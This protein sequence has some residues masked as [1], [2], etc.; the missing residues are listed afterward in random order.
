MLT[1]DIKNDEDPELVQQVIDGV[2]PVVLGYPEC[3]SEMLKPGFHIVVSV[4]RIVSVTSN[5]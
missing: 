1:I 4:V 5:F 2:D 3:M